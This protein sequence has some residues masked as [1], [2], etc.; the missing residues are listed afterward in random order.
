MRV[1]DILKGMRKNSE[2]C[3]VYNK[4]KNYD[5]AVLATARE[6]LENEEWSNLVIV[7]ITDNIGQLDIQARYT[8]LARCKNYLC[9]R[10]YKAFTR[11][12]EM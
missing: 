5:V 12:E 10:K 8:L 1:K 6:I 9:T 7:D 2:I 11:K 4:R 3:L